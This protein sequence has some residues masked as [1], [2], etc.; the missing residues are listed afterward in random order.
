MPTTKQAALIESR[1]G[2]M[3]CCWKIHLLPRLRTEGAAAF[4][5]LKSADA[6]PGL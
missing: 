5:L 6:P 1:L 2:K 4:R 3:S